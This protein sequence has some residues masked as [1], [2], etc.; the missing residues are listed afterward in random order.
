[1]TPAIPSPSLT[2]PEETV[3]EPGLALGASRMREAGQ[4][5][6]AIR[7]FHH[8][9]RLLRSGQSGLIPSAAAR[10]V[11]RLTDY[12]ELDGYEL[13]GYE[14]ADHT[15][16][17]KLNGG[18]G[19]SMGLDMPRCLLPVRNGKT[20]LDFIALQVEY[21]QRRL[22]RHLPLLFMNSFHTRGATREALEAFP[23]LRNGFGLDF[24]Q[25][26][27][28]KLDAQSLEPVHWPRDPAK[29]WCP[30]GHGD[31][32][33][34]LRTTGLLDALIE[35]GCEY[36]FLSNA[37]NLGATLDIKILGYM[38]ENG[39]PLL[40]EVA[41]R[42]ASDRKGGHLAQD[43]AGQMLIRELAQCPEAELEEF[44]D[45]GKYQFF[46][47]NNIWVHLPVL[48]ALLEAQDGFLPLPPIFNRKPVDPSDPNS[49]PI[50]QME[51]AMGSAISI[52][53][54]A[55]ALRVPRIRFLPVKRYEDLLIM[56]SDVYR[57]TH[58]GRLVMNPK[59]ISPHP[60]RAPEI[61]LD[62]A[63]YGMFADMQRRFPHGPPSL[64]RC[65]SLRIR[66]DVVFGKNVVLEGDVEICNSTSQPHHVPDGTL[67]QGVLRV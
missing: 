25:H 16:I 13:T 55:S 65:Q 40:M 27:I 62:P 45:I 30:P 64:V 35:S 1:M 67:I 10:P 7:A 11:E 59:R 46:N 9:H 51:S 39:L 52:V 6:E 3:A 24:E 8:Y 54:E 20:F 38:V 61:W 17:L 49:P 33:T 14:K 15:V 26:R 23:H 21:L 42:T 60:R 57:H 48:R 58:K 36:A 22:D 32:F 4:P 43:D 31:V 63:Y 28:P 41:H 34:S 44:Q 18:L 53:P 2:L 56:Q 5:M 66:G 12:E 47:T 50:I 37:D 19:T 29:E